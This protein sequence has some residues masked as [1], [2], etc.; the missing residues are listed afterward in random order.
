MTS[1]GSQAA[2]M[3]GSAFGR[4]PAA[5]IAAPLQLHSA[6]VVPEW[7]DYNN[8][9]SEW[10]YLLVFGDNADALFRFIGI[11][12]AYRA[13]GKSL[14]TAETHLRHLREVKLGQRLTLTLTV[15]GHDDKRLHLFQEMLTDSAGCVA[16]AEQM[17]LHVDA[18][19]GRVA[20]FGPDVAD[21][22]RLIAAAHT[23]LPR[24]EYV[25]GCM[26]IPER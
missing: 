10:A 12:E 3:G 15:L 9:L 19:V 8:H 2:G 5:V 16:T 22:L 6:T 20:P 11:D 4:G 21:S 24:P 7:V 23:S 26:R 14:Y 1:G 18:V 13:S 17:L 25:G